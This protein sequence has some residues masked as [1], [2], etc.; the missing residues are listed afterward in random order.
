MNTAESLVVS[1]APVYKNTEEEDL[2]SCFM[3]V[4][5]LL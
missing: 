4:F 1:D 3:D 5:H 2:R